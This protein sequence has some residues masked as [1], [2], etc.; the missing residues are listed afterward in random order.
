MTPNVSS[1][2]RSISC[3]PST[4]RRG[5]GST[6]VDTLVT[7]GLGMGFHRV[8]LVGDV[9]EAFTV[10]VEVGLDRAVLAGRLHQDQPG[11]TDPEAD[12]VDA[13]G[14]QALASRLRL[15]EERG[16]PRT[17]TVQVTHHDVEVVNATNGGG[18]RTDSR[19]PHR[20]D[21]GYPD[22]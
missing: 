7:Y 9:E 18:I 10:L 1:I 3:Q 22:E 21:C 20:T 5:R 2:S 15:A 11:F 16:I 13:A 14:G 19:A 6:V 4:P 12:Q 8:D 17:G